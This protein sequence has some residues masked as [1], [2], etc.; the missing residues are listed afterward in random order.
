[1]GCSTILILP[2]GF[3]ASLPKG[4]NPPV[5]RP[6]RKPNRRTQP[7]PR[8]RPTVAAAEPLTAVI[9]SVMQQQL[10]TRPLLLL[11]RLEESLYLSTWSEVLQ[12]QGR[13]GLDE[14]WLLSPLPQSKGWIEQLAELMPLQD[15]A[16]TGA[17]SRRVGA[18]I[19][20]TATHPT[21]P[22]QLPSLD[23]AAVLK[24]EEAD[25]EDVFIPEFYM[26]IL[27]HAYSLQEADAM[28]DDEPPIDIVPTRLLPLVETAFNQIAPKGQVFKPEVAAWYLFQHR[29]L[30]TDAADSEAEE[31]LERA[32]RLIAAINQ[33]LTPE[34]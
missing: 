8:S 25:I 9:P 17:P 18:V 27:T 23:L 4:L 32:E 14:R 26:R 11:A 1:M 16:E 6:P 5:P 3:L 7:S 30:L 21:V 34:A 13:A 20:R 15:S 12:A 10:A 28:S 24:R 29:S 22:G 2:S 31:T 33:L 19:L